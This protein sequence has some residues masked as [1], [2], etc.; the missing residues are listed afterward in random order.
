M[1]SRCSAAWPPT[2]RQ[3][4]IA[5]AIGREIKDGESLLIDRPHPLCGGGA[6]RP[7]Q[8]HHGHDSAPW[9]RCWRR[10]MATASIWRAASARRR[11]RAL[12]VRP[13]LLP[14]AIQRRDRD[15]LG[16]R[17][18]P[19]FGVMDHHMCEVE[20]PRA[21]RARRARDRRRRRTKF[22]AKGLIAACPL[23]DIDLIVTDGPPTPELAQALE[24]ANVELLVA[25]D[26][27]RRV[28]GCPGQLRNVDSVASASSVVHAPA[29][30]STLH[31]HAAP[32]FCEAE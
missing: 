4:R 16:G 26:D 11:L 23:A 22:T 6:A 28:A 10:A 9:R 12:M 13:A 21:G 14:R 27:V 2:W 31:L 17:H 1:T 20:V 15:H 3:K 25:G 24:A 19:R 8:P 32:N 5:Q 7:S 18:Q 29:S 30:T